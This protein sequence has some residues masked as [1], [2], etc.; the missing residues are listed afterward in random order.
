MKYVIFM[1]VFA[2]GLIVVAVGSSR[3]AAFR[4]LAWMG[5][6]S[7]IAL[8]AMA[9]INFV[10][11]ESYRGADR[12]FELTLTDMFAL[13]LVMARP[14]GRFMLK[15][16]RR[17]GTLPPGSL[18]LLGFTLLGAIGVG[19]AIH[20]L[21]GMF[22][23]WK[24]P[25][26]L[27]VYWAVWSAACREDDPE[28]FLQG[29]RRGLL[30]GMLIVG[31]FAIK[32]KFLDGM[33]RVNGTFDHSNTIPLYINLAAAPLLAWLLGDARIKRLEFIISFG[34]IGSGLVAV[35]ATQSRLGILLAALS[36]LSSVVVA[37]IGSPS[38]RS[39]AAALAFLVCGLIGG[40]MVMDTLIDRI[41]NA[42]ESSEQARD[43]FN[44]AAVLMAQDHLL[45][46]GLNNFSAA[47][48]TR[49]EYREHVVVMANEEQAG[50]AHHIY[51]LTAAETG[52]IGLALLLVMFARIL[53]NPLLQLLGKRR[54]A[55]PEWLPAVQ[56]LIL[57]GAIG[58]LA[59]HM[60]G[61]FEW[62]FRITP[63]MYQ[64]FVMAGLLSGVA[65]RAGLASLP[66]PQPIDQAAGR[67]STAVST[68][69]R[70]RT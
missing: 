67:G 34:I 49:E 45:G 25:R 20:P 70:S 44:H 30:L 27:L 50:V 57:A 61:F 4:S 43:E 14:L 21:Y 58:Q 9:S 59:M 24:L 8:G 17:S 28:A 42:P 69:A 13:G 36:S 63:V 32:Q 52:Y 18:A 2:G 68:S 1:T 51:L 47:M 16:K 33:Y 19:G 55:V 60:S 10:S 5:L 48:T 41:L 7:T 26:M 38:R 22:T 12:G 29:I 64:Y 15:P 3:S 56:P 54:P 6:A 37:N 53:T 23:V 66:G 35:L 46:V 31:L 62:A 39:K 40:L 65:Q 11:N